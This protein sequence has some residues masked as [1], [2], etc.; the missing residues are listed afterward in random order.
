MSIKNK[1]TIR[2]FTEPSLEYIQNKVL[3]LLW[4]T[5]NFPSNFTFTLSHK[6]SYI[7]HVLRII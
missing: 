7:P 6:C 4:R 2:T 5:N 3:F 1:I